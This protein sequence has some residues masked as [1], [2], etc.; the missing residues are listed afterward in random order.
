MTELGG[1]TKEGGGS[2]EGDDP[3]KATTHSGDKVTIP[4]CDI[5]I[6]GSSCKD[7]SNL[8]SKPQGLDADGTSGLTFRGVS[9]PPSYRRGPT[10]LDLTHLLSSDF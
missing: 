1:F 7:F 10:T 8:T 3:L 6:F 9:D 5:F 2:K 4:M